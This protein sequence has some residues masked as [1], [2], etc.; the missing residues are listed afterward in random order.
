MK[1]II[2]VFAIISS[3]L[4]VG[5]EECYNCNYTSDLGETFEEERCGTP[6]EMETFIPN[7]EELGWS[8]S[9]K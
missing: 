8:C 2:L 3:L 9:K 7:Q 4:F 5:C 6:N 1:K